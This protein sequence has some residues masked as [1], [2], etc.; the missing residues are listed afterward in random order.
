MR[1]EFADTIQHFIEQQALLTHGHRYLVA[2]SGGADSIAL[3]LVLKHLGHT[4]EAAHCN[5]HLRGD[6]SNRDE[7]FVE[8]FCQEQA[9][10]LHRAHFDTRTY[11]DLH[12]LSIEMAARE[13]RYRYFESL[14]SDLGAEAVCVAHHR[15]D[16]AETLLIN[17]IRGTGIHGLTGIRP[18]NGHIVRPLLCVS[19]AQIERFLQQRQQPYVTDSTNLV[20]DVMRNKVRLNLLPMLRAINPSIDESLHTTACQLAEAERIIDHYTSSILSGMRT[21]NTFC[22][23]DLQET[24]SPPIVLYEWLRQ[25]GFAPAVIRQVSSHLDAPTG[26]RWSS[27]NHELIID[28]GRLIVEPIQQQPLP[29]IRIPETG[30]YI[31]QEKQKFIFQFTGDTTILRSPSCACLDADKVQFPLT[32][33]TSRNGDRFTPFG[34]KGSR[35]LSDFLTDRKLSYFERRRQLV[36]TDCH[37]TIIW[38]VGMRPDQHFCVGE[39]TTK[40]LRIEWKCP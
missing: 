5:F 6:E 2:L 4:I 27:A 23:K 9:I 29:A 19:R 38:V 10:P 39:A 17:L 30:T 32:I 34:M 22:I 28:R 24:A 12:H 8:H 40:V 35:L 25:Y 14:R 1:H 36:V 3:A 13:L 21:E 33:R 20:D 15:D 16:S 37:D 11:A 18:R 26:R 7:Q 31:Y